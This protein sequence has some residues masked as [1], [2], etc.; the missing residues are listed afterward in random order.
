MQDIVKI[1]EQDNVAVALRPLDQRERPWTRPG[2]RRCSQEDIP[3]GHQVR[4]SG[5][6]RSGEEIIKYGFRIGYAKEDIGKGHWVHVHN[7]KTALGD[8]LSYTYEPQGQDVAPTEHAY[9]EGIPAQR[10]EGRHPQ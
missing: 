10:R 3:Q 2:R 5:I 9:F 6:S 8:I 7:L 4:P 1:N